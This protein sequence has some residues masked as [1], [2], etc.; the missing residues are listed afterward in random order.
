MPF[1]I[2]DIGYDL[3]I[4][5]RTCYIKCIRTKLAECCHVNVIMAVM[6]GIISCYNERRL[7]IVTNAMAER[8]ELIGI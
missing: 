6:H 1:L 5:F 2:T 3:N 7:S 4:N 8:N